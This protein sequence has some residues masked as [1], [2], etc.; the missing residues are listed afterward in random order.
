MLAFVLNRITAI[1]AKGLQAE[2]D[3]LRHRLRYQ[4][5]IARTAAAAH[6]VRQSLAE[7]GFEM[8]VDDAWAS[9]VTTSVKAHP[10]LPAAD[11]IAT[12]RDRYGIY[13]SG[14]LDDLRG[15]IFRVGHMGRAI[16]PEEVE[17]LLGAIR[18]VLAERGVLQTERAGLKGASA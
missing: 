4:E 2:N 7:M 13:I 17:L 3:R 16:E 10:D 12:L 9:P 15:K 11:L 14:G 8:F 18:E 5:R 1:Y 6:R